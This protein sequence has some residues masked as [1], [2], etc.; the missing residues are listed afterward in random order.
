MAIVLHHQTAQQFADRL[1]KRWRNSTREECARIAWWI[2]KRIVNGDVTQAQLR[3]A[4]D[5][6]QA[7][8]NA[9]RDNKLIPLADAWQAVLDAV[10]E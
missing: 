6:T 9:L 4:F 1:R 2:R 10:G 8:W 5:M 7:Q 3:T